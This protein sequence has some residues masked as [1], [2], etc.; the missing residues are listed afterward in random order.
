MFLGTT[1]VLVVSLFSIFTI[2]AGDGGIIKTKVLLIVETTSDW[3]RIAFNGLS[4]EEVFTYR[5]TD[6]KEYLHYS[7]PTTITYTWVDI[8]KKHQFDT[9]YVRIEFPLKVLVSNETIRIDITKGDI[10][11]TTVSIYD[12]RG[13]LIESFTD[14]ERLQDFVD[15]C[16]Q[17]GVAD[18]DPG[19]GMNLVTFYIPSEKFR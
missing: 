8:T 13:N 19:W 4:I 6:G 1:L 14:T 2:Q 5:I 7:H 11:Y 17:A 15:W 9:N 3:T 16:Y 18:A 12:R 10:G